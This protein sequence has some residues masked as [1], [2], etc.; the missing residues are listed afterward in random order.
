MSPSLTDL[1]WC[2]ASL[3]LEQGRMETDTKSH[4]GSEK[5]D[6]STTNRLTDATLPLLVFDK[7]KGPFESQKIEDMD[8]AQVHY[9]EVRWRDSQLLL[10]VPCRQ[11]SRTEIKIRI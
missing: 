7:T 10:A 8:T 4:Y 5:T 3:N 9:Y 11:K 2:I 6:R 1:I